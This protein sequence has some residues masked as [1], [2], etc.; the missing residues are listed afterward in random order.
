MRQL[1]GS[2][3]GCLSNNLIIGIRYTQSVC[4][5]GFTVPYCSSRPEMSLSIRQ[6]LIR[7]SKHYL[8]TIVCHPKLRRICD[9]KLHPRFVSCIFLAGA[10]TCPGPG[11]VAGEITEHLDLLSSENQFFLVRDLAKYI[12][13]D[14]A[15]VYPKNQV[16][17]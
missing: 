2:S 8:R 13:K 3:T 16:S 12:I 1:V 7:V 15:M 9:P 17:W 6:G 10:K 14:V 11:N 4:Y 5:A